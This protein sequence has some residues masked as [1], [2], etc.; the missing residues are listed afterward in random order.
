M[1]KPKLEYTETQY[2]HH[3]MAS[4]NEGKQEAIKQTESTIQSMMVSAY[5]NGDEDR[6]STLRDVVRRLREQLDREVGE[7]TYLKKVEARIRG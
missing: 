4:K 1:G 6:A 7:E 5:M 3:G 2:I